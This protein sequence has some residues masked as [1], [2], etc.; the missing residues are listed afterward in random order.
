MKHTNTNACKRAHTKTHDCHAQGNFN[1]EA[2][3]VNK[4]E[5]EQ[6]RQRHKPLVNSMSEEQHPISSEPE[7]PYATAEVPTKAE[8]EGGSN[9]TRIIVAIIGGERFF[10]RF[11]NSIADCVCARAA[12][13]AAS[14]S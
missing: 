10:S 1:A 13:F 4:E 6:E 12:T 9:R 11:F 14:D 3:L 8:V 7:D 5:E 2:E